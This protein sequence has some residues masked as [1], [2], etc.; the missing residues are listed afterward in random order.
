MLNQPLPPPL[1]PP[2]P[3]F[4]FLKKQLRWHAY[5]NTYEYCLQRVDLIRD[6]SK[7]VCSTLNPTNSAVHPSLE[8]TDGVC[9]LFNSFVL[10][11]VD[12]EAFAG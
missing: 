10:N 2:T 6:E 7:G 11:V 1:P 8:Q 3:N 5:K 12:D 9:H 4:F